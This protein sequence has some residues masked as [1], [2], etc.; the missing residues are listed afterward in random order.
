[1]DE[2]RVVHNLYAETP[3]CAY[4]T[5]PL[6]PSPAPA[7]LHLY[8]FSV[9]SAGLNSCSPCWLIPAKGQLGGK[10][11][12]CLVNQWLVFIPRLWMLCWA[13]SSPGTDEV[14]GSRWPVNFSVSLLS[15]RF[16]SPLVSLLSPPF[17]F[18]TRCHQCK[19]DWPG[20]C[21]LDQGGLELKNIHSRL[22]LCSGWVLNQWHWK[23][24]TAG[25][26]LWSLLL[27]SWVDPINEGPDYVRNKV[28]WGR[29]GDLGVCQTPTPE[30]VSRAIDT[31]CHLPQSGWKDLGNTLFLST[32]KS[33]L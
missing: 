17:L 2:K 30:A 20:I 22:C 18:E 3:H 29:V 11:V 26:W 28:T 4:S 33:S 24:C 15:P 7:S 16:L 8:M 6:S 19:H 10:A 21:W 5:G 13:H 23:P 27:K 12:C 9:V 31:E 25:S 32:G 14:V 1:M